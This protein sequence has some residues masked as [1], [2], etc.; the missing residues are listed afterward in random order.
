M[1]DDFVVARDEVLNA[2]NSENYYY[3]NDSRLG[4]N[5]FKDGMAW[6]GLL[7]GACLK[8]GDPT[9]LKIAR[10]C[11]EYIRNI[12]NVGPDARSYA[13]IQVE[14]DWIKSGTMPGMWYKKDAQSFAGPA[15]LRFAIDCGAQLNTPFKIMSRARLYVSL[16]GLFGTL[17]DWPL[18]GKMLRQ[19][20]NSIMLAH[21]ITKSKVPESLMWLVR[22]NPFY[23]YIAGKKMEV[24]AP[25]SARYVQ[26]HSE[27]RKEVVPLAKRKPST[28]IWRNW[29]KSEYVADI[30]IPQDW[31]YTPAAYVTAKYLQDSLG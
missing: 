9:A 6:T 10:K 24:V 16:G 4:Y 30:S 7:C 29:P 8:A 1:S 27:E 14:E 5:D 21:L 12:I 20:V 28:W 17:L 2:F 19:H 26:G 31:S 18:I 25:P 15:G 23:G 3:Y 22:E 11:E 13:P